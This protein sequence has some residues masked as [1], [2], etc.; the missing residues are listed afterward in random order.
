VKALVYRAYGSPRVLSLEQIADPVPGPGDV[1]VRVQ[2]SSINDFDWHLLTGRPII[3]R[4]GAPF[5]PRH[6]VLGADVAGRVEAVGSAVTRFR[7]G[8]E[9]FGDVS[10][11]GFGAFAE[12]V[13]APEKAFSP[14]P[15]GLSLQQAGVV[16]QAGALAMVGLLYR[17]SRALR[18]DDAVLVNG[19]GGGVGT[20]AVQIAKAAGA[21]VTGV[22]RGHKL[23]AVRAL[24]ADRVIDYTKD[25]FTLLGDSYD[26]ILDIAA[27]RPMSA[28]RRCLRPGG[29]CAITGGS[30]PRVLL[31]MAAGP[32]VSRFSSSTVGLPFWRPN[33][34]DDVAA[35]TRLLE[36]GAV[37]PV[38]DSVV[39]LDQVPEAFAR[40]GAQQH[41]GKIAVSV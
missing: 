11:F 17:G 36:R 5:R 39:T 6:L 23:D 32:L 3:N 29:L 10:P 8:D 7:P 21:T 18:T 37:R 9:V 27:H 40:F 28:Y 13:S 1:L 22:D 16:P 20:F 33:D 4:I 2:A 19:A 38:V 34:P 41:I 14:T 31:A 24:G 26:L 30:I 35:L 15:S 25:D 12:L